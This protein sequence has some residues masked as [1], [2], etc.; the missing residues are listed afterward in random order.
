MRVAFVSQ[1]C[2][3]YNSAL[4]DVIQQTDAKLWVKWCRS[5]STFLAFWYVKEMEEKRKNSKYLDFQEGQQ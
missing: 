1:R 3:L 2:V 5:F 4:V